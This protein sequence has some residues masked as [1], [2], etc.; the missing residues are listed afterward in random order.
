MHEF[1]TSIK[2]QTVILWMRHRVVMRQDTN[3]LDQ[4]HFATL[5]MEKAWPTVKIVPYCIT[6]RCQ[7]AEGHDLNLNI[8]FFRRLELAYPLYLD[9]IS[10]M[11]PPRA[12]KKS[13]IRFRPNWYKNER[14]NKCFRK[15][16]LNM[17]LR[18]FVT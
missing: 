2:I 7:K 8:F 11:V 14:A 17:F 15:K 4:G 18:L 6:T 5:G 10:L 9:H 16:I 1:T 3:A 13:A 12:G